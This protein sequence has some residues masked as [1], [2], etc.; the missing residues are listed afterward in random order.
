MQSFT[1]HNKKVIINTKTT[2]EID[3]LRTSDMETDSGL[4]SNVP[5]HHHDHHQHDLITIDGIDT[6]IMELSDGSYATHYLP[7]WSYDTVE[8]L[9]K[10]L[11]DVIPMFS[12]DLI[13]EG[14]T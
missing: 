7:Y 4:V 11:V 3:S 10:D 12:S 5:D 13:R 1:Y 8:E 14:K 2:H 6:H 9:S